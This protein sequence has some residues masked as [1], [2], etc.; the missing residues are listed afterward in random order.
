MVGT[1][2]ALSQLLE[3]LLDNAVKYSPEWRNHPSGG[4]GRQ[5]CKTFCLQY[6]AAIPEQDLHI[7][8][9]FGRPFPPIHRRPWPRPAIARSIV[10]VHKGKIWAECR[11][12]LVILP[13]H[14]PVRKIAGK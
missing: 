4:N 12:G 10:E 3:I 14:S 9:R 8:E 6:G 2:P 1:P 7:F 5:K 13:F 11:N